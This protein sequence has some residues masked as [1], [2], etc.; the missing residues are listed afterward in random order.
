MTRYEIGLMN[1]CAEY[2]VDGSQVLDSLRKS[3]GLVST[4]KRIAVKL[5]PKVNPDKLNWFT[6]LF[7]TTKTVPTTIRQSGS[8]T[9][10]LKNMGEGGLPYGVGGGLDSS[11]FS[12]KAKGMRSVTRL[13]PEKILAALGITGGAGAMAG[14][15]SAPA[16][17]FGGKKALIAA[18]LGLGAAGAGAAALSSSKKKKDTEDDK[19]KK[20]TK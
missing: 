18:L 9:E 19:K 2:G 3:A 7:T 6:R 12:T 15:S 10:A 14:G 17:S 20:K 4:G 5:H 1:K 8:V 11:L 16:P 13:S